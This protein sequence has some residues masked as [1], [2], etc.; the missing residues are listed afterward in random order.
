MKK[1][2]KDLFKRKKVW[3]LWALFKEMMNLALEDLAVV[4]AVIE[5]QVGGNWSGR[6]MMKEDLRKLF[7]Y[8]GIRLT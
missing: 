6:P 2:A 8:Q 5:T 4:V 1:G 7:V 3:G